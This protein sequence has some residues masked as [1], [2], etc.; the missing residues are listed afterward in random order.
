[1]SDDQSKDRLYDSD[2]VP[3]QLRVPFAFIPHGAP[4]P[5][6]WMAA[7]PGW[8][9]F[10]ATFVPRAQASLPTKTAAPGAPAP[11]IG[12]ARRP[13]AAVPASAASS[14]SMAPPPLPRGAPALASGLAPGRRDLLRPPNDRR[15]IDP[16]QA[17]RLANTSDAIAAFRRMDALFPRARVSRVD[18]AGQDGGPAMAPAPAHPASHKTTVT[19]IGGTIT[20]LGEG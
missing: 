13:E 16:I 6:E 5:L 14:R 9:K 11:R 2:Y 3:D 10:P 1:V 7:H 19:G 4:L 15:T 12:G 20:P 17:Y 18:E 8:V